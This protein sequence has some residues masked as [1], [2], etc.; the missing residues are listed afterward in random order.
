LALEILPARS[1]MAGHPMYERSKR[2]LLPRAVYLK[3]LAL[4]SALASVI[5][6]F[7]LGIGILGYHI[8]TN[9]RDWM[10]F[11]MRQ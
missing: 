2:P 3:R 6:G 4:H 11:K 10:R 7:S 9:C 1:I 5:I 8:S